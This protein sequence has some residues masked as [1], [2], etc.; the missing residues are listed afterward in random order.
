MVTDRLMYCTLGILQV[1]VDVA[2]ACE[3]ADV[4]VSAP[5]MLTPTLCMAEKLHVPWVPVCLGPVMPTGEF[6]SWAI[7]NTPF[8][9]KWLNKATYRCVSQMTPTATV[10]VV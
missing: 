2:A 5:L 10:D 1:L 8:R 6:P 3:G 9:W 7:S 4:I